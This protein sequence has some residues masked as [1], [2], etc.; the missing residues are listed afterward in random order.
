MFDLKNKVVVITGAAGLLGSSFCEALI[1]NNGI[2]IAIDIDSKR[3]K[4]LKA[5]IKKKFNKDIEVYK[6]DITDEKKIKINAQTLKKK[7]KKIDA[8]VNNAALNPKLEIKKQLD[9]NSFESF[10]LQKWN[11]EINVGLTGAFICSKHYGNIICENKMGGTIINISSDLGLIAP[12]Q[13]IYSNRNNKK[14]FK[15]VTYSVIKSGLIGL[16]KYLSTYWAGKNIRSNA[17]CPGGIENNQPLVFRKK[18]KKLI[19]LGRMAKKN[20]YQ[21]TLVWMLS[22]SNQ[23]LNGSI[24]PV[25]GGRTAW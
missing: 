2:P 16:T 13:S 23:Y 21:S 12:N 1:K 14:N 19:P 20:E 10:S 15:P 11:N 5:N 24:I 18:I 8:L 22:D 3:L 17:I 4:S 9:G 25:D 6:V 7:Y